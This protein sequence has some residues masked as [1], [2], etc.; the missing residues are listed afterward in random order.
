LASVPRTPSATKAIVL[1]LAQGI[2]EVTLSNDKEVPPDV[3][4]HRAKEGI[5][6]GKKRRKQHP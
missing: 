4:A 6:G 2:R 1:R 3:A 5:K